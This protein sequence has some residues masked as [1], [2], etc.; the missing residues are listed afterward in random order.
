VP[1]VFVPLIREAERK[2]WLAPVV[3]LCASKVVS[4]YFHAGLRAGGAG[5]RATPGGA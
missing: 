3:P 2:A 4:H 5:V 1:K